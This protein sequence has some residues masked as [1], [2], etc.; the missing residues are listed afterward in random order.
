MRQTDGPWKSLARRAQALAA[1]SPAPG[2]AAIARSL[3]A[4]DASGTPAPA[5]ELFQRLRDASHSLATADPPGARRLG[6][7][8]RLVD[9]LARH[10]R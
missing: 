9:R 10:R 5:F 1:A 6:R 7:L 3:G 4:F 8:A 2:A